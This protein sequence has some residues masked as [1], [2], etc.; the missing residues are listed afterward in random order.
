MYWSDHIQ[1]KNKHQ[2]SV[3][4]VVLKLFTQ[5]GRSTNVSEI[6][7][8]AAIVKLAENHIHNKQVTKMHMLID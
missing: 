6:K 3:T 5:Q 8:I 7:H 4:I 1:G 2:I